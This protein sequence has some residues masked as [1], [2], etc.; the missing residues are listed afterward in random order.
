M[1][2]FLAVFSASAV[3]GAT[4]VS[5][6]LSSSCVS[7]L[8][9]VSADPEASICLSL[10]SLIPLFGNADTS[11]VDPVNTWVSS[12]CAVGSCSNDTIAAVVGNLTSGCSTELTTIGLDTSQTEQNVVTAQEAYPTVR[13]I[14]C[15]QDSDTYCVTETLRGIE[16]SV[17]TLSVNRIVS[18]IGAQSGLSSLPS[19][20]TCSNCAKAAYNILKEAD[21]GLADNG[22]E[23]IQSQ[24]GESFTD[25]SSP[26]G[27]TE[28]AQ[29]GSASNQNNGAPTHALQIVLTISTSIAILMATLA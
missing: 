1:F 28:T 29:D 16:S 4:L 25:G 15:L 6:Q 26:S 13:R 11:I 3:L 12:I 22:T 8:S 20:V 9:V 18:L 10:S 27:I 23:S 17:G 19:N 14:L 5:A 24:C 21:P 7:A 2:S